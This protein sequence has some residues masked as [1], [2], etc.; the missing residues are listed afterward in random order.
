MTLVFGH[1]SW[2]L[3]RPCSSHLLAL[4]LASLHLQFLTFFGLI[5]PYFKIKTSSTFKRELCEKPS[6]AL[7][8]VWDIFSNPFWTKIFSL[9]WTV[10]QLTLFFV[11]VSWMLHRACSSHL[12][13]L[14]WP[15][16]FTKLLLFYYNAL[17]LGPNFSLQSPVK[18]VLCS[19]ILT[20]IC[21]SF[22]FNRVQTFLRIRQTSCRVNKWRQDG[23]FRL[24]L[25]QCCWG[26]FLDK[27]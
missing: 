6:W 24:I 12:L 25:C 19:Q 15:L 22:P 7:S 3:H 21:K 1:V 8:N 26:Y 5:L 23:Q 14:F 4:S 10:E 13:A 17:N 18:D 16:L 20:R 27:D 11:H 2:M 9:F